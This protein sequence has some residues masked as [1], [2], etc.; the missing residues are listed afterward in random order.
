MA[1]KRGGGAVAEAARRQARAAAG[2]GRND[3]VRLAEPSLE[4]LARITDELAALE[5]DRVALVGRRDEI[6]TALRAAGVTWESLA[7][8]TGTT[9]QAL[10]KRS[11]LGYA[12]A[13]YVPAAVTR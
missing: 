7:A 12:Q 2:N 4:G 6:V 1:K 3:V 9:R 8:A 11:G 10:I 5:R 13:R